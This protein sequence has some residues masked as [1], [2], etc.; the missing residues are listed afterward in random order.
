V[1]PAAATPNSAAWPRSALMVRVRWATS[2]ALGHQQLAGA[3]SESIGL[4]GG[5]LD[6]HPP[7]GRPAGGLADRLGVVPVGLAALDPG[8]RRGRRPA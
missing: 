8:L 5:R 3:Q 7:P 6:H 4:L 1:P 2:G